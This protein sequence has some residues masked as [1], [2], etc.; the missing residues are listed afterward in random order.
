MEGLQ[1][2]PHALEREMQLHMTPQFMEHLEEFLSA[3]NIRQS[4]L[5]ELAGADLSRPVRWDD[6]HSEIV[7]VQVLAESGLAPSLSAATK[8]AFA[9]Y[10]GVLVGDLVYGPESIAHFLE[11]VRHVL[12]TDG[13]QG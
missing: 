13:C 11:Y 7:V 4:E 9:D 10:I 5:V 1:F 12:V 3:H 6:L 2:L 8:S